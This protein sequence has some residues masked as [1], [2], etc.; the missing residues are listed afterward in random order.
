MICKGKC[1]WCIVPAEIFFN[2]HIGEQIINKLF[3]SFGDLL[4]RKIVLHMWSYH[5]QVFVIIFYLELVFS[6]IK[7]WLFYKKNSLMFWKSTEQVIGPLK[8]KSPSKMRETNQ[9]YI[10]Q[11]RTWNFFYIFYHAGIITIYMPAFLRIEIRNV[12]S[13]VSLSVEIHPQ[14]WLH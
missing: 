5:K 9:V 7:N 8:N 10:V 14:D 3:L 13:L 11:K 12:M 2:I 1:H 6:I 4:L